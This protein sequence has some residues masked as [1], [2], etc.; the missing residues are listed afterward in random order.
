[1]WHSV[2]CLKTKVKILF[3]EFSQILQNIYYNKAVTLTV[4]RVTS[5]LV[6]VV[7]FSVCRMLAPKAATHVVN[8]SSAEHKKWKSAKLT[9]Q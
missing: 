2:P 6:T 3:C 1:M 5:W 4:S 7:F 8:I 9:L